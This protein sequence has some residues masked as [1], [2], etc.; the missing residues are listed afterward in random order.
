MARL[1]VGA[2]Y[3]MKVTNT[4]LELLRRESG[5]KIEAQ[6]PTSTAFGIWQGLE[7]TRITC[8]N[9]LGIDKNTVDEREQIK[10]F[11][12]YVTR[13]YGTIEKAIKFWDT[14]KYY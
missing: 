6:N 4:E 5:L 7:S 12:D 1:S 3:D 9:R 11:R 8:Q 13:R 14:N 2:V 10:C